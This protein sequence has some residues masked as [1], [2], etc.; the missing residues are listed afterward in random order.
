[1]DA[2]C[3]ERAGAGADGHLALLEVGEE[4]V[5]LLLGRGAVLLAGPDGSPAGDERPVRLDGFLR[6]D[7]FIAHRDADVLM[8]GDDLGDMR[9][10]PVQDGVRDEDPPEIVGRVAERPAVG[11]VG[12]P[13]AGQCL[14]EQGADHG[15][16]ERVVLGPDPPLEQQR[17]RRQPDELVLVAGA[18]QGH[19]PVAAADP[20]DDGAEHVREL[21]ADED[22]TL[23]IGLR[24]RDLQQRDD[25][26][27]P[28]SRYWTR[29]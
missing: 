19:C 28:G 6:V 5:P 8:A 9:R 15:P 4:R 24:W 20:A 3:P 7:G 17:R 23:H 12:Q 10:E 22:E 18:D 2:G 29:L 27:V 21:R 13:G 25:S 11:G 26:P 16:G 1:M 14:V